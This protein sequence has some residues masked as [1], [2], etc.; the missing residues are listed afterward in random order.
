MYTAP[1]SDFPTVDEV[2][3]AIAAT[4]RQYPYTDYITFSGHG[5]ATTHSRFGEIVEGVIASR[6]EIGTDAKVA[7]L[8]NSALVTEPKVCAALAKLDAQFMKLDAGDNMTWQAINRPA[9]HLHYDQIVAGLCALNEKAPIVIQSLLLDGTVSNARGEQ[10]D[11]LLAVLKSIMPREVHLY[12]VDR[13]PAESSVQRVPRARLKEI[14]RM[15][16]EEYGLN[17]TAY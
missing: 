17:A 13:N 5:E 6:D 15:A 7:I 12:T 11:N 3:S 1:E 10:L 2:L 8:S 9:P 16:R 4:V 14:E